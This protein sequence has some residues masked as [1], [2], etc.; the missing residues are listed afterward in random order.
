[1]SLAKRAYALASRLE[2]GKVSSMGCVLRLAHGNDRVVDEAIRRGY[3][4]REQGGVC[5]A[6]WI[7]V[8]QGGCAS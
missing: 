4:V 6:P 1:M 5:P 7:H 3:L 8:D 2:P